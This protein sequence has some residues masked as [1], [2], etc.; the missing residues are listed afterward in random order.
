MILNGIMNGIIWWT[1]KMEAFSNAF[2]ELR[3]W[4]S[5]ARINLHT[6]MHIVHLEKYGFGK[7]Q[8]EDEIE[9]KKKSVWI[10]FPFYI[11]SLFSLGGWAGWWPLFFPVCRVSCLFFVFFHFSFSFSFSQFEVFVCHSFIEGKGIIDN[12]GKIRIYDID[13][14][15]CIVQSTLPQECSTL[16]WLYIRYLLSQCT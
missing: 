14:T 5:F 10:S 3:Q 6:S 15:V 1:A 8:R 13:K 4:T 12:A 11:L 16:D 7:G 9:G 2:S